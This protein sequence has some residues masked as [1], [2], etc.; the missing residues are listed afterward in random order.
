MF[1][2]INKKAGIIDTLDSLHCDYQ[3]NIVSSVNQSWA[4]D[5]YYVFKKNLQCI[6]EIICAVGKY[7]IDPMF[8]IRTVMNNLKLQISHISVANN[9]KYYP[10][11]ICRNI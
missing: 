3:Y 1:K 10:L 11:E 9:S 8:L 5:F 6:K 2:K 7:N 4:N